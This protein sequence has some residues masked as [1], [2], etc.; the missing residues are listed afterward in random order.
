MKVCVLIP[1]ICSFYEKFKKH[2]RRNRDFY[3]HFIIDLEMQ[4]NNL[5]VY[6]S[7]FYK[8]L[9]QILESLK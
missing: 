5:N 4:F 2:T 6:D 8:Q 1:L 7:S 3:E 9:Y